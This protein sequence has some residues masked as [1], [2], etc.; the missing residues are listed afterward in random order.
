MSAALYQGHLADGS[1]IQKHSAGGLY[2]LVIVGQ[3]TLSFGVCWG[4]M[5]PDGEPPFQLWMDYDA[6]VDEAVD[7]LARRAAL[8]HQ[9]EIGRAH[10]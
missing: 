3:Q 8:L 9:Q 6:A 10:V 5:G 2:P 4:V 7:I 1:S